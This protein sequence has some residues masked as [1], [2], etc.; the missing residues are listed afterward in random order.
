MIKVK[1]D[2]P[3]YHYTHRPPP[4]NILILSG[5]IVGP[6]PGAP[7]SPPDAGVKVGGGP[8]IFG[9]KFGGMV[10]FGGPKF[11]GGG[12]PPAPPKLGGGGKGGPPGGNG[13]TVVCYISIILDV[14]YELLKRTARK[15]SGRWWER[16]CTH[17]SRGWHTWGEGS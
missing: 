6:E 2:N 4:F 13:G 1:I 14:L 8:L 11:P 7:A 5:C 10:P 9:G 15:P 3:P 16:W 17:H 12:G